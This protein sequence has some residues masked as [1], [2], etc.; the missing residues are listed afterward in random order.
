MVQMTSGAVSDAERSLRY[1]H[2]RMADG[3]C[4]AF[5]TELLSNPALA[6]EV[7]L[8]QH[9]KSGFAQIAST[10]AL[11]PPGSGFGG[12]VW[13]YASVAMAAG[14]LLGFL[15]ATLLNEPPRPS[16]LSN[17]RF[18]MLDSA[19]AFPGNDSRVPL[20]SAQLPPDSQGL[21]IEV[22]SSVPPRD[23]ASQEL[24]VRDPAG[25]ARVFPGLNPLDG[26][27]SLLIPR[28]ELRSGR[29]KINLAGSE[30]VFELD[31]S[32]L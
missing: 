30:K 10:A 27:V 4:E 15:M 29:Y 7:E 25:V 31:V 20:N 9:F 18:V 6:Q 2:G 14:L 26:Y 19:R 28:S 17:L 16:T 21:L 8:D 32:V 23:G 22:P 24:V 12:E 5:E 1:V 13:R 3:E 11:A